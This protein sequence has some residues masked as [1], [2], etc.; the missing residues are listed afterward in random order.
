MHKLL[1]YDKTATVV[2]VDWRSGSHREYKQAVA[3]IRLVGAVLAH[4]INI[5]Y[6]ELQLNNL[7]KVHLIGH[8]LGAHCSGYAGDILQRDFDLKIGR[9]T[10]LDPADPYFADVG[11]VVRLDDTDAKYV[12]IIHSDIKPLYMKGFGMSLPIGHIDFYPNG[13]LHNPGCDLSLDEFMKL[14]DNSTSGIQK[15]IS[16][17]HIRSYEFFINSIN[18]SNFFM[19]I[20]CDSYERFLAGECA[21]CNKNENACFQFGFHS[22]ISYKNYVRTRREIP[23]NKIIKAYLLT[24]DSYPFNS[25]KYSKYV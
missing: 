18:P 24:G 6:E 10:G 13:G 19:A 5:L 21:R 9:I 8:S 11:R 7:D 22:L 3:N 12:D 4:V 20:E 14:R 16:C 1:N 17:D 2:I 23:K 15:Y 25:K